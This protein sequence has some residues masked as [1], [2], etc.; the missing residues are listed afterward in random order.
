MLGCLTARAALAQGVD[1]RGD[2]R[3][4]ATP[5][6]RV[7]FPTTLDDQGRQAAA[8]AERAW[9]LLASELAPPRGPVDLVLTDNVDFSN[10][11]AQRVPTN[12]IVIYAQPPIDASSLRAFYGDWLPI[13]ITH[14]LTHVFHLDRTRGVWRLAQGIFGRN[15]A[16]FPNSYGPSWLTEGL[17]V[18]FESRLTGAGRIVGS[19]HR[20]IARAAAADAEIP[21]LDQLSLAGSVF[22]L[23]DRAYAYGSL[24]VDYIARHGGP[25][26]VGD[27][28]DRQS[29]QLIPWRLDHAARAAFGLSF[30]DAWRAWRDSVVRD[31]GARRDTSAW[32]ELTRSGWFVESP[33]WADAR[34]LLYGANDGRSVP[35][36]ER[37]DVA[38]DRRR[39]GR[40]NSLSPNVP[41]PGGRVLF[42]QTDFTDRFEVRS[43]LW[44]QDASVGDPGFGA[45]SRGQRRLTRGARLTSPDARADGSIVAVQ[46]AAGLTWLVRVSPDGRTIVPLTRASADT[47]WTEP[48]WSPDGRIVAA[49]QL[50]R[51]GHSAVVVLDTTGRALVD[52]VRDRA[53]NGA[54]SWSPDGRRLYWS[55]DRTGA[56]QIYAADVRDLARVGPARRL[57]GV[58]TGLGDPAPSP[59][60]R[61]LGALLFHVDGYHVAVTDEA[62]LDAVATDGD[63][64]YYTA[65]SRLAAEAERTTGATTRYRPWRSLLPR[66]WTP[67]S[68][69]SDGGSVTLGAATSGV[70]VLGRHSYAAQATMNLDT[71]DLEG[72]VAYRYARLAQ[73]LVDL[74][75]SQSWVYDSTLVR[76]SGVLD[77]VPLFRRSRTAALTL[78]FTRPRVRT[79]ASLSVG[80]LYEQRGYTSTFA[81][82]VPR[83]DSILGRSFPALFVSA[84]W[85]NTRRPVRS[86]S[87]EDGVSLSGSVQQRWQEG[88]L[89]PWS[90]RATGVGRLFKSLDL[91]GFAHH[92]LALRA[93]GGATDA[94]TATELTAGGV[95]GSSAE[96]LPGLTI[97]DP[98]RT[99]GVR[100]FAG[101]AQQGVRAAAGSVEYRA[102]LALPARGARLLPVFAD[103]LFVTA[104]ADAGSAWCPTSVSRTAQ[105]LCLAT[106]SGAPSR[107]SPTSPTWMASVGA[108]LGLDAALS[109]DVPYR[110]RL[111]V[112]APV[113]QRDLAPSAVR[114]YFTLGL[115]F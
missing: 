113:A 77:T 100:G 45:A 90:R 103:R 78:T 75:A 46:S 58:T 44:V 14:E 22:P 67:I 19:Q 30:T 64:T 50:V 84:G 70:D 97:G 6:F 3:T 73:P 114:V 107:R 66:Y 76:A 21:R 33:R 27:F 108:E 62:R 51:G 72:G 99:F 86:I 98:S 57:S 24:V 20:L 102:P 61:V 31:V 9:G 10:G 63:A 87:P 95:S 49:V 42:A 60:G 109:Y 115:A 8:A 48:R 36:L 55:S 74:S 69:P 1:P 40:R 81:P 38:G 52:A 28:V 41:L 93:A 111:G 91:P 54:P 29:A 105:P 94:R 53:V 71:R 16:L 47:Q 32:R 43:D 59:D 12:R 35:A 11:Y 25:Q 34:T 104:F 80:A 82:L 83:A 26:K 79:G 96:V 13:V 106:A 23:G 92:V 88:R 15:P 37:V 89:G 5:H 18:Y 56:P 68:G 39:L 2:W 85:S 101:G 112:A 7:H 4:L 65:A 17:A 110:F